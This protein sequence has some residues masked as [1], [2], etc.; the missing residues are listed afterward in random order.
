MAHN[1]LTAG[2]A[3][4][5][6]GGRDLIGGTAFGRKAGKCLVGGTGYDIPLTKYVTIT[7]TVGGTVAGR[8][9][10]TINGVNYRV[11]DAVVEVE[12]GTEILCE[13]YADGGSTAEITLNGVVVRSGQ[14][15]S[16]TLTADSDMSI[17]LAGAHPSSQ[18]SYGT[19][20]ITTR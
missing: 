20:D 11:S 12:R 7:I 8:G 2:T 3:R 4:A 13:V 15:L 9:T 6:T 16:Y 17:V 10:V 19:I 1:V 14:A 5:I 18:I